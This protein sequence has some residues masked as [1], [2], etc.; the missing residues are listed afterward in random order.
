MK[1]PTA[2]KLPSGA[3]FCRVRIDGQDISITRPTEKEAIAEAMAIKAGIKQAVK[4]TGKDKTLTKAIDAY[5]EARENVLSPSTIRGYRTIQRNRFKSMMNKRLGTVNQT[6][7]QNAVN[8]EAK[9]CSAKTLANSWGLLSSVIS[10][11]TGH[12]VSIT[13]PQVV[14]E[15]HPFLEPEQIPV[16]LNAVKGD[17]VEIPSLLALSSLRRSELKAL[18]LEKDIDMDKRLVYVNGAMVFNEKNKLVMKRETKNSTSRRVVPMIDPLYEALLKVEPKSGPVV[19]MNINNICGRINKICAKNGLPQVGLH[20]LRHSFASLAYHLK[21]REK[22]AMKIG[23][24]K[25]EQTMKRIYTH[26]AR[27]DIAKEAE[28]FTSFFS[29]QN[30]NENDNGNEIKP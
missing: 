21:I 19:K 13:L 10:E 28:S 12:Q 20:G 8:L 4:E 17:I 2:R 14:L 6:Q 27:K 25:D 7:W 3:W 24:W 1:T 9:L 22:T 29:S 23:G 15:E 18:D 11:A 16:F 26:L 30:G 5:I